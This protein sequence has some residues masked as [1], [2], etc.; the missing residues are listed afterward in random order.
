MRAC[1]E[2]LLA[3]GLPLLSPI[4]DGILSL[5][6]PFFMFGF[7]LLTFAGKPRRFGAAESGS[8]AT[9]PVVIRFT[10]PRVHLW[11]A[12]AP[13]RQRLSA[14]TLQPAHRRKRPSEIGRAPVTALED[15]RIIRDL[16]GRLTFFGLDPTDAEGIVERTPVGCGKSGL[17]AILPLGVLARNLRAAH[18]GLYVFRHDPRRTLRLARESTA[19]GL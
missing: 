3:A 10:A 18:F 4:S 6:L 12:Q 13:G 15:Q 11:A 19:H 1:S 17:A 14:R 7:R 5:G 2:R 16:K 8:T 9:L